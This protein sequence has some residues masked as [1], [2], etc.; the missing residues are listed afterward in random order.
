MK[1]HWKTKKK[2]RL[3]DSGM[4]KNRTT[5]DAFQILTRRRLN[6]NDERFRKYF[7]LLYHTMFLAAILKKTSNDRSLSALTVVM[8]EI[9]QR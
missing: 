7:S 9:A 2:N 3:D 1:N 6:R 8:Q 5:E 4:F